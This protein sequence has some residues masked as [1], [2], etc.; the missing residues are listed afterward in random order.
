MAEHLMMTPWLSGGEENRRIPLMFNE[1][2]AKIP[3]LDDPTLFP[4]TV[5]KQVSVKGSKQLKNVAETN[6]DYENAIATIKK[7]RRNHNNMK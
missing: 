2:V 4:Q 5:V 1:W 3:I 6:P 7:F